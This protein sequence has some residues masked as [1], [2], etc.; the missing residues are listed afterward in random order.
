MVAKFDKI[1]AAMGDDRAVILFV[2][3]VSL[4]CGSGAKSE[5]LGI[6]G[7]LDDPL[8]RGVNASYDPLR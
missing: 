2:D 3:R 5:Q 1:D 6:T 7:D 4:A 8:W